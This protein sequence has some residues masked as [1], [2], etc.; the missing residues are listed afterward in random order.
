MKELSITVRVGSEPATVYKFDRFPVMVGRSPSCHLAICHESIPRELFTVWLE[1]E[2]S[3]VRVEER[4]DLK[5][6]LLDRGVPVKSGIS[7]AKLDLTV[8]P[9]VIHLEAAA[10]VGEIVSAEG[11]SE[12]KW[13]LRRRMIAAA[14]IVL[15]VSMAVLGVSSSRQRSSSTGLPEELSIDFAQSQP[16][17]GLDSP[18]EMKIQEAGERL[19]RRTDTVRNRLRALRLFKDAARQ[20]RMSQPTEADSLEKEAENIGMR[21]KAEYRQCRRNY[22]RAVEDGTVIEL[23]EAAALLLPWLQAMTAPAAV[24]IESMLRTTRKENE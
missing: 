6:P 5:N 8:G 1:N 15:L 22:L 12:E 4:P 2:C 13:S 14:G 24:E 20:L 23:R 11:T 9:V 16:L 17:E 19:L 21:L 3:T 7:G 18:A 10:P